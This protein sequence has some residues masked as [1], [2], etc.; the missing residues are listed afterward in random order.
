[1]AHF[2]Y[3]QAEIEH[4]KRRDKKLGLAIDT[5][6][7]IEREITPDVFSALVRSI[8]AQQISTRAAET[9]WQRLCDKLLE[10]NPGNI[11]SVALSDIQQCG[12]SM[13]KA[14]YIKNI[15][16]LSNNREIDFF[17][18]NQ[19]TDAEII[20]KLS[21]IHGVGV[22]T[23]EMLLIFSLERPDVLSWG[24]F[25]IRRGMSNLYGIK[26]LTKDRFERLRKRYSPYGSV[27]SL[28][29]WSLSAQ[30]KS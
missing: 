4:L 9:V 28:Y 17:A 30:Q 5:I 13:R 8:V 12:L 24:D 11:A 16:E 20:K 21:S 2:K 7:M 23:A 27:A 19:L 29:L 14:G 10:I 22:W 26:D 6:G 25:A 18:L 15:A 3:G 1:M